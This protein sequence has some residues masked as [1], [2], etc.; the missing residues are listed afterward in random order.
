M[1]DDTISFGP[2]DDA[3]DA[4]KTFERMDLVSAPVVDE[5]GKLVG[6]LTV[7]AAMDVLRD[8]SNLQALKN[9]GL[10]GRRGPVRGSMEQRATVGR[11]WR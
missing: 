11:G 6:R 4:V 3:R 2:H 1:S 9:A 8:E 7:D 10:S 5:R